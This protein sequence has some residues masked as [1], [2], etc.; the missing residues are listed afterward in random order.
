MERLFKQ[1]HSREERLLE[2]ERLREEAR[3]LPPGN[4]REELLHRTPQAG[5][6]SLMSEWLSSPGLQSPT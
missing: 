2:A 5:I 4:A 3:S 1:S 6:G